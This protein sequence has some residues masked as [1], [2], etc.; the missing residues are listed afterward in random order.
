MSWRRFNMWLSFL[1]LAAVPV[2]MLTGW[3]YSVAFISL[4]SIY[5]NWASHL[6]AWRADA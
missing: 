6:A 4:V 1:W 3:I 2:A 5:A